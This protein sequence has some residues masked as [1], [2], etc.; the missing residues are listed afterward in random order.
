MVTKDETKT[1]GQDSSQTGDSSTSEKGSTSTPETFTKEDRDKAVSDALS[2]AG[3]TAKDFESRKT[4][5]D[6]REQAIK[7]SEAR[8]I[9]RQQARDIAE[10]ES[11]KDDPAQLTIIQQRQKLRTSQVEFNIKQREF[12]A[13]K[14]QHEADKTQHQT[15]I[16]ATRATR[17]ETDIWAIAKKHEVDPAWL[18]SLG[19]SDLKQ[20][21][22]IAKGA[23]TKKP[24]TPDSGK[25]T[26]GTQM[27]ESSGAKIK[28]GFEELHPTK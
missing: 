16:E 13:Q 5:L 1:T 4:V 26:G 20:L 18:K 10:L 21:E 15:E 7:D 9:E 3:R 12:E 6:T 27:P 25:T 17:L 19:V 2:T 8:D 11:A 23:S 14:V 22:E 24:F 28:A